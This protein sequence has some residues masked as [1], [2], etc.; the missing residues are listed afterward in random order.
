MGSRVLLSMVAVL[1][2]SGQAIARDG[3]YIQMGLGLVVSPAF[4][5]DGDDNDWSTKCDRIINPEGLEVTNECDSPPGPGEWSQALGGGTGVQ[6]GIA[7]GY[8]WG[9]VRVEGEYFHRVTIYNERADIDILDDVTLDKQDQEIELAVGGIDDMVSHN[10]FA[11]VYYGIPLKSS[12]TPYVGAGVGLGNT[13][14]YYFT[15]WKRNDDPDKIATFEDPMLKA[16]VAGSTTIGEARLKDRLIGYQIL[17][18]AN[19]PFSDRV[20]LDFRFRMADFGKFKSERRA[21]NQLRSHESSVGRGEQIL[22]Q[23]RTD[24]TRFWG[25][26]LNL[27]YQ[28]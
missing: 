3:V 10:F 12:L 26:T 5:M 19:Y 6:S 14:F 24:D 8:R 16:K 2:L 13:S 1:S 15:H 20:A 9:A 11:N 28:F 27:S 4:D 17:A 18:G 25:A 23:V 22:Y 7:L 21:W